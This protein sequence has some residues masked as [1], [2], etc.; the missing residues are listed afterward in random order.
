MATQMQV[1]FILA[2][3]RVATRV[4]KIATTVK[5]GCPSFFVCG[6]PKVCNEM[7]RG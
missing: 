1:E 7:K 3:N 5:N 4:G 6:K 2:G